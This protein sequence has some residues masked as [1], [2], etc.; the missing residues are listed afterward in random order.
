VL[1]IAYYKYDFIYVC[2]ILKSVLANGLLDQDDNPSS[3]DEYLANRPMASRKPSTSNDA[4]T[5]DVNEVVHTVST[6]KVLYIISNSNTVDGNKADEVMIE[7]KVDN[8]MIL[9][10]LFIAFGFYISSLVIISFTKYVLFP[11]L[12]LNFYLDPKLI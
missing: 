9:T 12:F 2:V 8:T 6:V 4:L 5:L 11:Y 3:K 1:F 10:E 7:A